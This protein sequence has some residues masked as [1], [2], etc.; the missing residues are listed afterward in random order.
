MLVIRT[1]ALDCLLGLGLVLGTLRSVNVVGIHLLMLL[2]LLLRH[3][4]PILPFL[5]GQALPLL[6]N[7]FREVRLT[8][9]FDGGVGGA[10]LLLAILAA[11]AAEQ[12]ESILWSLDIILISLSGPT[13]HVGRRRL[14][15]FVLLHL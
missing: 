2:F 7:R 5:R 12:D 13:L 3:M 8:L 11:L 9:L 15:T 14:S 4:L 1:A 6:A 10:L